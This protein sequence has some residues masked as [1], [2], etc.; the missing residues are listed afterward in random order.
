MRKYLT[1][2]TIYTAI[3]IALTGLLVWQLYAADEL[4]VTANATLRS[5][6]DQFIR[7]ITQQITVTGTVRQTTFVTLTTATQQVS[8]ASVPAPGYVV[9]RNISTQAVCKAYL[10]AA[11]DSF[12]MAAY[13]NEPAIFRIASTNLF[14]YGNTNQTVEVNVLSD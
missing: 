8:L 2:G 11:V 6:N 7:Q 10:G 5:G 12:F 4:T 9:V 1:P 13:A 3:I 14:M